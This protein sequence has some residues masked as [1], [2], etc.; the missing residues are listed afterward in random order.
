VLLGR[1]AGGSAV[2]E[3]TPDRELRQHFG[4]HAMENFG[5]VETAG[6]G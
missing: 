5:E 6:I 1:C 4:L 2:F 3:K